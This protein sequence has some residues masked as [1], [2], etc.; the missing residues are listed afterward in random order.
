MRDVA[1][2]DEYQAIH[3]G[4]ALS[5]MMGGAAIDLPTNTLNR[6]EAAELEY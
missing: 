3:I 6:R 2:P 4:T 1:S 5:P